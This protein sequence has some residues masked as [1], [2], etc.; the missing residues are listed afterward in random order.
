MSTQQKTQEAVLLVRGGLS[1]R[2]AQRRT[3]VHA[4]TISRA[5]KRETKQLRR[6]A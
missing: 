4:S 1:W 5:I 2:E 3:G 6:T